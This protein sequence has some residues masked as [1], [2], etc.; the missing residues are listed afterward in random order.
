MD[1]IGLVINRARGDL[2]MGEKMM[3][4][5]DIEGILQIKLAGVL[6]E[7]DVVFLSCGNML[8]SSTDSKKAYKYLAQN[9]HRGSKKIFNVVKK[10]SGFFGSI[11]MSIK[12]SV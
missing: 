12:G 8:P 11:R 2:M 6:P 1:K 10:Y 4:P 5:E 7:E 9:V 3:L